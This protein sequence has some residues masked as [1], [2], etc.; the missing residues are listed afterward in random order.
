MKKVSIVIPNYNQLKYL[1][2]CV[3]HCYFQSYPN[4]EL[5]IVDGGS[6]DGTKE[7]LSRLEEEIAGRCSEPI[8]HID[9]DGNIIKKLL[10]Y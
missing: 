9:T 1:K 3:D 6:T 7:Y 8:T 2:A 4:L 5:I 10:S